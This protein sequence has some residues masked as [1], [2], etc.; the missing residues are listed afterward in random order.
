M[1]L[2]VLPTEDIIIAK[3]IFEPTFFFLEGG[4]KDVIREA[5]IA[6]SWHGRKS[7]PTH[8]FFAKSSPL[9]E[10]MLCAYHAY[11]EMLEERIRNY[12]VEGSRHDASIAAKY[13]VDTMEIEC[14]VREIEEEINELMQRLF[15][16]KLYD[17]R[18][19]N[20]RWLNRDLVIDVQALAGGRHRG[21]V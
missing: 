15:R 21:F 12:E 6:T 14:V 20:T 4:M 7:V 18:D 8:H 16:S 19:E 5:V 17:I 1:S 3:S 11:M 10:D 2:V 13:L 9:V